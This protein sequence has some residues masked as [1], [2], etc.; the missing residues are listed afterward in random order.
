MPQRAR[1]ERGGIGMSSSQRDRR[2][3]IEK[4]E[5]K[6]RD[7]NKTPRRERGGVR[8]ER[9]EKIAA[10]TRSERAESKGRREPIRK[11][12]METEVHSES[13]GRAEKRPRDN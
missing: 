10:Q 9:R 11:E 12:R 5:K 4:I 3:G 6:Q 1:R 8:G 7:K 13:R 2:G